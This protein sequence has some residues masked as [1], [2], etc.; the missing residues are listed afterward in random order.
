[1]IDSISFQIRKM[2]TDLNTFSIKNEELSSKID[3]LKN[4][5]VTKEKEISD[6]ET[7]F[8]SYKANVNEHVL[9]EMAVH[10]AKFERIRYNVSDLKEKLA[11]ITKDIVNQVHSVE[12][13]WILSNNFPVCKIK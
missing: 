4:D 5:L 10:E 9:D 1:M 12:C 8:N 6:I 3:I 2:K 13:S 11:E 7:E